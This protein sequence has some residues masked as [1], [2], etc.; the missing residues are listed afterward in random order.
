[1][2]YQ[3]LPPEEYDKIARS[4]CFVCR[5]VAGNP[6]VAN[7]HIIYE[8]EQIIAFLNQ[9]PTQEG[10]TIVCPKKHVERFESELTEAEWVYLQ[11]VVQRIAQ[12]V[13]E[14]T[15]AIRMYIASL[16]SPERNAHLHIHVCPCPPDTPFREQQFA[17]MENKDGKYLHLSEERMQEIA[18]EI[19]RRLKMD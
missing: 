5:I 17:A 3:S 15:Q 16:G 11:K 19:R 8:D 4:D 6:L 7:P 1:M 10:Y 2:R 12:A 18:L 9:F 14:T 13:S